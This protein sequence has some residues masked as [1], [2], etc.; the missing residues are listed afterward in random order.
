M[1]MY[2]YVMRLAAPRTPSAYQTYLGL[3]VLQRT[4]IA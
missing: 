1:Y 2:S 4:L 3:F